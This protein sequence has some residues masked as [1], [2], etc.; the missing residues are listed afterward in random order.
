MNLIPPSYSK[1]PS[2]ILDGSVAL[3]Q[4]LKGSKIEIDLI[5]NKNL[6]AS[7][8]KKNDSIIYLNTTINKAYGNFT[9]KNDEKFSIHLVDPRGITNKDP[10]PYQINIIPDHKPAIKIIKPTSTIVLGNNQIIEYQIEIQ[11]DY[12]FSNLQLA[13][14]IRRPEYLNVEPYIAMFVIPDLNKDTTSQNINSHWM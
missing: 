10:I 2:E 13:Y 11:D 5:S 6:K 14:E 9:I 4:G 1:L 8:I 7:F 12:G 3:I